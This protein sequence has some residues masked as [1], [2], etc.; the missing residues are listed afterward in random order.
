MSLYRPVG[1]KIWA[2]D[3]HFRGQRIR[4][5]TGTGSKTLAQK[6]EQK[7]R[8]DLEAGA[9]GIKKQEHPSLVTLAADEWIETKKPRWSPR[10]V[11]IAQNSMNHLLPIFGKKLLVDIEAKDIARYQKLRLSEEASG[12]TVNIEVGCL[13]SVMKKFGCWARI[14]PEVAMLPEREDAGCCLTSKE[15]RIL[16]FECGK[17]RSRILLPFLVVA[18]ET[19]ARYGTVR[20]LQWKTVDFANRCLTLSKDKTRAGSHRTIPLSQRALD[21]LTFWAQQFPERTPE[22]YVFPHER[23]GGAGADEVFGFTGSTV[24]QSD[25]SRPTGSIKKAWEQAR[26]RAGLPHFRLHDLRH[27]GV[28][29]MIG[30]GVPLPIIAKIVGWSPSTMAKMAARYGHFTVEEMRSAVNSISGS[31]AEYPQFPPRSNID[32]RDQIQ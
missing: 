8:R 28:S 30:A 18:I 12:R 32:A 16:L 3:F 4:E 13:R 31:V 17:S 10:M 6:I 26:K 5:T 7:R 20:R 21:T 23:Y 25:P 29:R 14:Q 11:D 19:A 22:H 9:A 27:T 1:S 15:E 2:M 24:Y